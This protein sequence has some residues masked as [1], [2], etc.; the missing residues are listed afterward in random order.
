VIKGRESI[1]TI[2]TTEDKIQM[3]PPEQS[4]LEARRLSG[5]IVKN[6]IGVFNPEKNI[7]HGSI[8]P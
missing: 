7:Q 6:L 8:K 4:S 5:N 3:Q 1:S 2:Q